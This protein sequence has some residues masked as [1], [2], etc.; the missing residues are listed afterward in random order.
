MPAKNLTQS[1]QSIK[2]TYVI[3]NTFH[4]KASGQHSC[5]FDLNLVYFVYIWP[6]KDD[7]YYF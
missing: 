1:Y 4:F 6:A 3:S 5:Q 7:Q 2:Q